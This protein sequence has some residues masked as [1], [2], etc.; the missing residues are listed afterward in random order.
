MNLLNKIILNLVVILASISLY[1]QEDK[2]SIIIQ[3][4]VDS[5]GLFFDD[6]FIGMGNN[7]QVQKEKGIYTITLVENLDSWNAEI[8]IDTILVENNQEIFKTINFNNE[9]LVNTEPEDVGVFESDSLIGFTPLL[10]EAGFKDLKLEKPFFTS[11]YITS[12]EISK[13]EIPQLDYIGQPPSKQFY[14][15]TLFSILLGTAIAL[16]AT[17]AYLKLEADNTFEEYKITGDEGLIEKVNHYD[18]I[19]AVTFVAMEINV[20]FLIYFFL[21]N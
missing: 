9:T 7:F 13:G 17:T 4:N 10:I 14:G 21:S 5:A 16:G 3:T 2:S 12:T 1:A 19:S 18:S 6:E 11:E 8:I 20:G 15:S